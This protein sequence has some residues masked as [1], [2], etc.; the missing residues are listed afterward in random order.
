[1]VQSY[2]SGSIP[3]QIGALSKLKFLSLSNNNLTG[4]I[5]PK[6]GSLSNLMRLDL[7]LNKLGGP[8]LSTIGLLTK[9]TYLNLSGNNFTGSIDSI[10]GDL[11][12]LEHLNLSSNK[13]GGLL[14]PELGNL[15][16]LTLLDLSHSNLIGPI[17]S[18]L[19]H[20]IHLTFLY[21]SHNQLNHSIPYE[22]TQLV[23]LD[24][25]D[26]S[27][28]F[29]SGHIWNAIGKLFNPR[30]L[31]LSRNRFGGSVPSEISNLRS[32]YVLDL[33][34][35]SLTG[36]IPSQLGEIY[37]TQSLYINLSHNNLS[38]T[39]P[40]SLH[41]VYYIDLS[42]NNLEG[43]IPIGLQ[44][45]GQQQFSGNKGLC[46]LVDRGFSAC[47]SLTPSKPQ[48]KVSPKPQKNVSPLLIIL[49][50]ITTF[51]TILIFGLLILLKR[52]DEKAEP[53]TRATKAGDVFSIWNYDGKIAFEDIVEATEDFDIK[54]CVGTGGYGS[55]YRAQLPNDRVVALKKLHSL[56]TEESTFLNSFQNEA[57]V[58][59]KLRHRNIIKLYGFCLHKKCMVLIYEYMERGSLFCVLRN[60]DEAI[61]LDWSKR[62]NIVKNTAHAL[63]YLHHD[64]TPSIV[65]RDISSNNILL[66]SEL[67]AYVADFGLAR[68]L[69]PDSSNR[70]ILAGTYG[71]IAPEL[72][73]TMVV[74]EKCDVY[75]FGVVA[76]ETLMGC[77]PG[78]LLSSLSSSSSQNM[79][80]I[81]LLDPRLPCV[82]DTMVVQDIALISRIAFACLSSKP[83][84]RPTMHRV[85]QE[86]LSRK[87]PL[88]I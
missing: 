10:L 11:T 54:Y 23:H 14:P 87:A 51:L 17:P 9:L 60:N 55:V 81:D 5:P 88:A 34:Y 26:L 72:A 66:N 4:I 42:Y 31:N 28:N 86:F 82:T 19:R 67:E 6:I 76:L 25:L 33:S 38:G 3:S 47:P 21:L 63:S 78:E 15:K 49:L 44:S 41:T 57:H 30:Y 70:T 20:L 16:N 83:K 27:S 75:S 45:Q 7:S 79:M 71:Y 39:I 18:T 48:M 59:S 40:K 36:N 53:E 46:G 24:Y 74:T 32:L 43:E 35:N 22:L 80:L 58:L 85:S 62:V 8:I 29:L 64:C 73:Y 12:N 61:E 37:V 77:H 69:H 1:M 50:P 2:L 65:H 52:K 13:L 84:S 56:E 68:L